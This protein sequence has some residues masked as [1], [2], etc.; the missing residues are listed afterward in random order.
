MYE[1]T[2]VIGT[3][4]NCIAPGNLAATLALIAIGMGLAVQAERRKLLPAEKRVP[5]SRRS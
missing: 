1:A 2:S 3:C 4:L 5:Q